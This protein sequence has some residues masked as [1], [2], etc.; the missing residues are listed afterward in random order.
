MSTEPQS[1]LE[2]QVPLSATDTGSGESTLAD[3]GQHGRLSG[4]PVEF[5]RYRLETVLGEGAM[6]RV[7]LAHD[8]Q[9][10][11]RVA[12][13]VPRFD[14]SDTAAK[15]RFLRE[16]RAAAMLRHPNICPIY[17]IGEQNGFSFL[18]MAFIE[19]KLLTH[20]TTEEHLL[21]QQDAARLI[22]KVARAM[23]EAHSHDIV[24]RDLKPD[25]VMIDHRNEPVI[26]DFGLARWERPEEA[27]LTR[28]GTAIGTPAYMPPEQMMGALDQIGPRTDIYS[29][30][31][32]LFELVAGRRPFLGSI[33]ALAA[34]VLRDEPPALNEFR[35][36]ADPVL[37]EV[38]TKCLKKSPEERF[39]TAAEMAAALDE[40]GSA[41]SLSDPA[42]VP[43]QSIQDDESAD[44]STA[45]LITA[46]LDGIPACPVAESG[47][48][49]PDHGEDEFVLPDGALELSD[50]SVAVTPTEKSGPANEE[51][52]QRKPADATSASSRAE[53]VNRLQKL[54]GNSKLSRLFIEFVESETH[55]AE[56]TAEFFEQTGQLL[57]RQLEKKEHRRAVSVSAALYVIRPSEETLTRLTETLSMASL[58]RWNPDDTRTSLK[59]WTGVVDAL[60]DEDIRKRA[61]EFAGKQ[62]LML[63]R[64][65]RANSAVAL[66]LQALKWD[67]DPKLIQL[68]RQ[69]FRETAEQALS[70]GNPSRCRRICERSLKFFPKEKGLERL[71]RLAR[72]AETET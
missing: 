26:M 58:A 27:T 8:S 45:G 63:T 4:I 11:R 33:S 30:G 48:T 52:T 29:L 12:L 38:C 34:Q 59:Y 72:Q 65:N 71:L 13:K 62:A 2:L 70:D 6:G 50:P 41:V 66:Y 28:Q 67:N 18:S 7:F 42:T 25:N 32:M 16:A 17:D 55:D 69:T 15:E 57:Q 44:D 19:G 22:A 61:A 40:Y 35:P 37:I 23:H 1:E 47:D 31:V 20:H 3:T 64:I 5:G 14:E 10:D 56:K 54:L 9:L 53:T 43:S 24:H 68:L 60:G 39:A 21:S 36:D 51:E 46:D 49:T